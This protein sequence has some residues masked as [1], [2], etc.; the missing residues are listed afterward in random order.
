MSGSIERLPKARTGASGPD[1]CTVEALWRLPPLRKPPAIIDLGCGGGGQ[2]VRLAS[3][4]RCPVEAL[5][6]QDEALDEMMAAARAAGVAQWV[7]PRQASLEQVPDRPG[8]YDLVWSARAV[9]AAGFGRFLALWAPLLHPRG[10]LAVGLCASRTS[11][12]ARADPNGRG[13][14]AA[15]HLAE[16]AGLALCD[17]F[18]PVRASSQSGRQ[19]VFYLFRPA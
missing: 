16:A 1:V 12:P 4:F 13:D 5:D 2:A 11:D 19:R 18:V 15:V 3:H 14:A 9:D 17:S 10:I 8:S 7:R 6:S